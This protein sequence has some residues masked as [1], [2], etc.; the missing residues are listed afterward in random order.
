M[1]V[2]GEGDGFSNSGLGLSLIGSVR[3]T[4]EAAMQTVTIAPSSPM[5]LPGMTLI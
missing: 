2:V 1:G 3:D 5:T 4:A